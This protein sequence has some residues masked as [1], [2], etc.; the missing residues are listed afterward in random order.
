[1]IKWKSKP[2]YSTGFLGDIAVF[3]IAKSGNQYALSSRLVGMKGSL[4]LYDEI[5]QAQQIADA[6]MKDW[7]KKAGL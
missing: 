5:S 3:R 2:S 4:G 7:I 6:E 1:M